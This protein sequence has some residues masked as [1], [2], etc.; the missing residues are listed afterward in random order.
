M[1]IKWVNATVLFHLAPEPEPL[2]KTDRLQKT[3]TSTVLL[4][5]NTILQINLHFYSKLNM[6]KINSTAKN[7]NKLNF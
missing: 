7:K 5:D 2:L 3:A 4:C 6:A 1:G